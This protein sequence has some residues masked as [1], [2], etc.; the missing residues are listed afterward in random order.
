MGGMLY[1]AFSL[2]HTAVE[3]SAASFNAQSKTARSS[4]ISW[5]PIFVRPSLSHS[6]QDQAIFFDGEIDSLTFISAYSH[7]MGGRGMARIS[8]VVDGATDGRA[9]LSLRRPHRFG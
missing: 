9:A 5:R 4:L 6:P 7:A 2:G 8:I 1:G 3:K